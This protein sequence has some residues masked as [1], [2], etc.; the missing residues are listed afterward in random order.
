MIYGDDATSCVQIVHGDCQIIVKEYKARYASVAS[1]PGCNS[2]S[3]SSSHSMLSSDSHRSS[4]EWIL[5]FTSFVNVGNQEINDELNTY[6]GEKLVPFNVEEHFDVL[7]WWKVNGSNYSI[8]PRIA[9][10]ILAIL[11]T[12]VASES[13][14]NTGSRFLSSYRNKL[15]PSTL[16]ALMCSQGWIR[17]LC[18]AVTSTSP[19]YAKI[20]DEKLE[21]ETDVEVVE[22]YEES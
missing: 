13:T 20:L 10:D 2:S 7:S 19:A 11:I 4:T 22:V 5:G 15:H 9:R 18:G 1:S 17:A 14:F 3:L 21:I 8:V 16:D 12:T 6:L